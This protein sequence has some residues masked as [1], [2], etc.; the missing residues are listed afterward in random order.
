MAP[1]EASAARVAAAPRS[2]RE[3]DGDRRTRRTDVLVAAATA[4]VSLGLFLGLPYLEALDP[5]G[6]GVPITTPA[7]GDPAWVVM[8][9]GFL[10][11]SAALLAARQAPRAVLPVVAAV[12]V[13]VVVITSG[14]DAMV[15]RVRPGRAR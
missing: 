1:A 3:V 15:P 10:V 14:G 5:D 2:A 6:F 8:A 7:V 9:S 11:Q 4:V 13:L 12:P